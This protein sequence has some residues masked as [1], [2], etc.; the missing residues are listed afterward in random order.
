MT[1]HWTSRLGRAYAALFR[2]PGVESY[3]ADLTDRDADGRRVRSE[4]D[5]IGI[6]FHD[7]AERS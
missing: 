7:H 6:R 3:P 2:S 1:S 5:A 4:L